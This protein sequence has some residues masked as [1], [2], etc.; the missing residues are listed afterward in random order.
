MYKKII[1]MVLVG[2]L[3]NA[4][5]NKKNVCVVE[6]DKKKYR[7]DKCKDE[8]LY[9]QDYKEKNSIDHIVIK[10]HERKMYLYKNNVVQHIVPISLGKNNIGKKI[11]KG[12]YKTPE[13]Q[14][15]IAD[16][17]CSGKYYRS[18]VI[19]YPRP[20]DIAIAKKRGVDPGGSIT[21]HGQPRWNASGVQDWHTL[22]HNWTRGCVAISNSVMKKLWYA[23]KKDVPITILGNE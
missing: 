20:Y 7:L 9:A 15:W 17:I 2:F 21:I 6:Y 1:L 13:G 10:K 18:I 3:F 4:C 22:K 12:D 23:V 11:E 8:L 19:S 14:F 5:S 16:K